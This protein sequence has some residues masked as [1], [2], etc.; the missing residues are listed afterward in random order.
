MQA[1]SVVQTPRNHTKTHA[2]VIHWHRTPNQRHI[3]VQVMMVTGDNKATA[4]AVCRAV[5]VL[6]PLPH[7]SST[8]S[9]LSD[10]GG[11]VLGHSYTGDCRELIS[12]A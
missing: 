9:G 6:D 7:A 2:Y 12:P 10:I 5:G 11:A 8:A 1:P 3:L 4:E